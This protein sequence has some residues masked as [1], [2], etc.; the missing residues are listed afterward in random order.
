MQQILFD[1]VEDQELWFRKEKCKYYIIDTE[2]KL[3]R[4]VEILQKSKLISLDIETN[5]FDVKRN[6]V[7]G[8]S[9][10]VEVGKAFYIPISNSS[11]DN[12]SK[13][14][15]KSYLY[16]VLTE[17]PIL[18]HNIKF[19]YKFILEQL[20]IP[21]NCRHDTYIIAKLLEEFDAAGLKYLGEVIFNF[22]V[23][24]L[25]DILKKYK[26]KPDTLNLLTSEEL[27]E[28]ACQD[29]DLTLRLFK[30]FWIDMDW[31]P[32]YIYEVEIDLIYSL[33]RMEM[34]GV[35]IDVDYLMQMRESYT[36]KIDDLGGKIRGCLDLP[37]S[38]NIDSNVQLGSAFLEKFPKM[39]P[40]VKF[41]EKSGAMK[42]NA[43]YVKK[44]EARFGKYL[45]DNN[46][47]A[48][49]NVFTHHLERKKC[50]SLLTKY[51]YSWI[52]MVDANGTDIL[53]TNFNALGAGTGRMSSNNPNMQNVAPLIRFAIIPR[54]GYYFLAMD[55]DQM[56][57]RILVAMAKLVHLAD[58]INKE[59]ADVHTI[60]ACIL[61]QVNLEVMT[62]ALKRIEDGVEIEGDRH[63]KKLRKKA[64]T[65]NFGLLYGMGIPKLAES[66]GI[67]EHEAEE[68]K[69]LYMERFLRKTPWFFKVKKFARKNGHVLTAFGRKR[70]IDNLNLAVDRFAPME[71]QKEA[72]RLLG[73]GYRK[74][75]N[76]PIQGTSAD[77]MKIGLN[78]VDKYLI[79]NDLDIHPL[80]VVHDDILFEV[81]NKYSPEDIIP[82]LKSCLEMRFK[83]MVTLTVDHNISKESWGALKD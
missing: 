38:F 7:V 3:K 20:G 75:I 2:P 63:Y 35:R 5:G 68:L 70:R 56:E 1:T 53:L 34:R 18:G 50:F 39:K 19:D 16:T 61:F 40:K 25:H 9:F 69:K 59:G 32:D 8:V 10:C 44:Y 14:M 55:Y 64:K 24:E 47:P 29:V 48:E 83:D 58:E 43:Q 73:E 66:L 62:D 33:A 80:I 41:T 57:Y 82:K 74:A 17:T 51:I 6:V 76:T 71:E 36:E 37:D 81:N 30:Y 72:K 54:D 78:K 21:I 42:L 46:F 4:L 27:F 23:L 45:D 77:I 26:M 22:E 60:A 52:N 15:F 49:N 79:E 12:I 31:R 11:G 28:Y 13:E 65:L 67:T